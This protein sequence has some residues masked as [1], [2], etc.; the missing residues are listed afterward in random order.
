MAKDCRKP[1][2]EKEQANV[3][4]ERS[5]LFYLSA[6]VFETNMVDNPNAWWVDTGV[7][8][9]ICSDKALFSTYAQV[10]GRKL[11]MVNSATSEVAGM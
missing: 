9:H 6:V 7:T 8:R 10:S 3:I 2:K 4:Q 5:D 11:Y 1:K